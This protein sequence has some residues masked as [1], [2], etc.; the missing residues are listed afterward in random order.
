MTKAASSSTQASAA[1]RVVA[2]LERFQQAYHDGLEKA[3]HLNLDAIQAQGKAQLDFL[4]AVAHASP[5]TGLSTW[6]DA[7]KTY[8][9]DAQERSTAYFQESLALAQTFGA[10]LQ[11]ATTTAIA[12]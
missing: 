7:T 8:L 1:A 11:Q 3:L 12:H 6:R 5:E 2:P 9:Q 4:S 10:K